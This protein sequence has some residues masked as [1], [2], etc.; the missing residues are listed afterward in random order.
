MLAFNSYYTYKN[1]PA[2]GGSTTKTGQ[3]LDQN[4]PIIFIALNPRTKFT[5][6]VK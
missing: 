5:S 3:L 2:Q 4:I 6:C 1:P